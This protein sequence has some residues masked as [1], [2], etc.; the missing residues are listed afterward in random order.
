MCGGS[1]Y[2]F[3][4]KLD[5]ERPEEAEGRLTRWVWSQLWID[6][7]TVKSVQKRP[8]PQLRIRS[9][10]WRGGVVRAGDDQWAHSSAFTGGPSEGQ[11][12]CWYSLWTG[13]LLSLF[14]NPHRLL[15]FAAT[16][17]HYTCDQLEYP[18]HCPF[19]QFALPPGISHLLQI[20]RHHCLLITLCLLPCAVL[21]CSVS[22]WAE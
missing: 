2:M 4:L 14:L 16:H 1:E 9:R 20:L 21:S 7:A 13:F 15:Q 6:S 10:A 8:R 22:K 12:T 11:D 19:H 5:V 18:N 3:G 17:V